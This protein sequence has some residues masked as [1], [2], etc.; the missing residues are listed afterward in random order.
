[1]FFEPAS[2]FDPT[3]VV[4]MGEIDVHDPRFKHLR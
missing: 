4:L 1:M 3:R 2:H